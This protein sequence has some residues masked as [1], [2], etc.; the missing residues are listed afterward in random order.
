MQNHEHE[1]LQQ[2]PDGTLR[3]E[4]THRIVDDNSDDG[5]EEVKVNPRFTMNDSAT[6][7]NFQPNGIAKQTLDPSKKYK[8]VLKR[9]KCDGRGSLSSYSD[10]QSEYMTVR[11]DEERPGTDANS[12]FLRISEKEEENEKSS[13]LEPGQSK[14]H[15]DLPKSAKKYEVSC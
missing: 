6:G 10:V 8:R 3:F 14:P 11:S 7:T 5:Y 4:K 12:A 1:V 13:V 9:V 15:A 2:A